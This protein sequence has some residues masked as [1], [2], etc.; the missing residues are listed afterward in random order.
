M[1]FSV[2]QNAKKVPNVN[3]NEK[4]LRPAL[5]LWV[6]FWLSDYFV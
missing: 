2:L 3:Q 6:Y 5:V 1:L 4:C